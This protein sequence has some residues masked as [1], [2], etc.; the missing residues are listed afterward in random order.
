M[1]NLLNTALTFTNKAKSTSAEK[2]SNN[3]SGFNISQATQLT[4][5]ATT[6][7]GGVITGVANMKIAAPDPTGVTKAAGLALLPWGIGTT[8]AGSATTAA[9]S[10]A[11]GKTTDAI[12]QAGTTTNQTLN[13][14]ANL[15]QLQQ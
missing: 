5:A 9:G 4:G 14:I 6:T 13:S 8:A 1:S 12:Q 7:T 15:R 3:Q 11:E 10:L 2:K